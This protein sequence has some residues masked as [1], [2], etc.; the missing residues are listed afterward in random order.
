ML[1]AYI[2]FFFRYINVARL[3]LH[4]FKIKL[5]YTGI[6]KSYG[7]SAECDCVNFPLA[8][9]AAIKHGAT[10]AASKLPLSRSSV[11]G[12]EINGRERNGEGSEL[13]SRKDLF[14]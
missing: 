5:N 12:S 10:A 3:E 13:V 14:S 6:R 2:P 4:D 7:E 1:D 11:F 8:P 9:D